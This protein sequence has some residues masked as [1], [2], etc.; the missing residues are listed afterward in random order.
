ML[1]VRSDED[2]LKVDRQVNPEQILAGMDGV[3]ARAC[4]AQRELLGFIAEADR[5][6]LWVDS[7]ARDMAHFLYIRY[8]ISDWKARRWIQAA[9]ALEDL[10]RLSE[11]F[12]AGVLGIDKVVELT[13]FA[14]AETERDPIEWARDVPSGR[15][16]EEGDLRARRAREETESIDRCR[17]LHW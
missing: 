10:P 14:T 5:L 7:G 13:R 6:E 17:K 8:G 12:T 11:A 9:H 16:R 1:E 4:A 2:V 15:I 3:H